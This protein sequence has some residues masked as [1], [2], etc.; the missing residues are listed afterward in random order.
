MIYRGP[1]FLAVV[2][3]VS[4]PV[5]L[6]DGRGEEGVGEEPNRTTA[7]KPAALYKSLNTLSVWALPPPPLPSA[8]HARSTG[9]TEGR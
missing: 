6:S 9:Y 5:E 8:G 4:S 7:R 1:G 3:F 2:W